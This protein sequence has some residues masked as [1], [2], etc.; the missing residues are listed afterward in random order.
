MVV[1]HL[2]HTSR[3]ILLRT[4]CGPTEDSA[5]NL[6]LAYQQYLAGFIY[7]WPVMISGIHRG[8]PTG[9]KL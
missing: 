2:E 9:V 5:G 3:V 7:S 6:R 1:G 8:M 4:P